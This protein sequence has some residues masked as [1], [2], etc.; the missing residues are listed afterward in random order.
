[1]RRAL[2]GESAA[3]RAVRETIARAGPSSATVL[4][5]GETGTGK[6]LVATLLH[7]ASPRRGRPMVRVNCA[8]LPEA[9]LESELFG[10]ERGA[11]TGADQRRIGR[12]EQAHG[13]TLFL[14]EIGDMHP[15]IQAKVL[16]ALQE[17]EFQRLGGAGSIRVDVRVVAATNQDLR[18]LI[19]RGRFREDLLYRLDVVSIHLPP[20]RERMEDLPALAAEI[21]AELSSAAP[22]ELESAA[23]ALLL[24][25]TW[26][27][28]VRELRNV[29][30]RAALLGG[31][32]IA[33]R[34]LRLGPPPSDHRA[35]GPMVGGPQRPAPGRFV[36]LPP[37]GA[38]HRE[39]E[40]EL[41]VTA[42]EQ[43]GW[44]QKDAAQLL[45]MSR[46]R[47]NYRIRRLGITHPTWRAN[48][49]ARPPRS[50]MPPVDSDLS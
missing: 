41:I 27:G 22:A 29:L 9:L 40:R 26:P 31:T 7:Q 6:E 30:E 46:R 5:T 11:F 21:L 24:A 33:A 48:R 3:I 17:R 34:D 50:A 43:A 36:C 18:A 4:I 44:V 10:H 15:H 49:T 38:D 35:D 16:R 32:R 20:L 12:F 19:A 1:V 37:G 8:A 25:H 47:L 2:T 39:V 23:L 45:H 28:N 13:G 42:L 14:D